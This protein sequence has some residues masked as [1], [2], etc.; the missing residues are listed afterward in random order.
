MDVAAMSDVTRLGRLGVFASLGLKKSKNFPQ[1]L[2]RILLRGFMSDLR[3][4]K[5]MP[6]AR[7]V[8]DKER[9]KLSSGA[10]AHDSKVAFVGAE[11]P[12]S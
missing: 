3:P 11:A 12:T 2:K 4:P 9:Q 10:K 8:K 1:A 7:G 5:S 6:F